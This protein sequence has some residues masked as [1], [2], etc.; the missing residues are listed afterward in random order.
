MAWEGH[1]AV[2]GRRGRNVVR[3]SGALE[4]RGFRLGGERRAVLVAV[5]VLKRCAA[6]RAAVEGRATDP[7]W[8]GRRL[9]FAVEIYGSIYKTLYLI[10]SEGSIDAEPG[11]GTGAAPVGNVFPHAGEGVGGFLEGFSADP[12]GLDFGPAV[13]VAEGFRGGH[14]G[15][16]FLDFAVDV[17]PVVA[18]GSER[19]GDFEIEF[20]VF[21]F[22]FCGGGGF[23]GEGADA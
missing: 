9:R 6:R 3:G 1:R 8:G 2:E 17:F 18:A 7:R 11:F 10:E 13:A 15:V 16:G 21:V 4:C 19:P 5:W 20:V 12:R 22:G 14:V 23:D